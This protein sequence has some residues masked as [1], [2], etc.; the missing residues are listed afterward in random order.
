VSN[1][2]VASGSRD[3][4]AGFDIAC[5]MCQSTVIEY[6]EVRYNGMRGKCINCNINFPLD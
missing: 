3:V 5:L 2:V 4:S 6:Y 1:S